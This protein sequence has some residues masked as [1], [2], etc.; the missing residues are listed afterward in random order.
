VLFGLFVVLKLVPKELVN[1]VISVYFSVI[2]AFSLSG[3]IEPI[4]APLVH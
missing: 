1:V 3:L 4:L 2:G